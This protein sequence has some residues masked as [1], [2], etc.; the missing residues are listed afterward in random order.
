MYTIK[1]HVDKD[2]TG[3]EKKSLLFKF[4]LGKYLKNKL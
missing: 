2:Y 4:L 3:K 1:T